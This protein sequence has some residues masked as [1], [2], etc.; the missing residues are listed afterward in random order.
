M[1]LAVILA[2]LS[3]LSACSSNK[4]IQFEVT[5]EPP[6]API[7]VNGYSMGRTPTTI[8]LDCSKTWVGLVN[9]PDGWANRSGTY[10][11]TAYPPDG[12]GGDSQTKMIDPCNWKGQGNPSIFFDLSLQSVNPIDRVKVDVNSSSSSDK[13]ES[14]LDKILGA[15]KEL[16]DSG[17]ITQEEYEEKVMKAINKRDG[18]E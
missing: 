15:L 16:R 5:S 13:T 1:R 17:A 18:Q 10:A 6:N 3:L 12:A 8:N 2:L 7:E 4:T 9:S 11:V 14:E